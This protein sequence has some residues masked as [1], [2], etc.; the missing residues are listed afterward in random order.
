[1][2]PGNENNFPSKIFEYALTGRA[3]L[4]SPVSGVDRVLGEEAVYFDIND[5]D[6]S[7]DRRL[8]EL[9]A[10]PRTELRRRGAAIQERLLRHYSWAQ[11]GEKLARFLERVVTP[12]SCQP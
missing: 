3:I 12:Q 6:R 7:L 1:M 5:Y 2:M 10:I 9:A 8:E 4:T 11:Q